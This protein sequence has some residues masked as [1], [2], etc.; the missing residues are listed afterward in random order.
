M[1]RLKSSDDLN[2]YGGEKGVFKDWGR[3]DDDPSL[4]QSSSHRSFHY[5]SESG[6]KG[7]SSSS[8]RY[9]RVEDDRKNS[10]LI[11]K[12]PDYDVDYERRKSYDRYRDSSERGILSSSP[13]GGGGYVG[14]R[15]HRSE[16]FS[17][18]RRDFP[19]GF[20]SE[21]DRSRREGSV[22][23]WRRFSGGKDVEEGAKSGSDSARGSKAAS[24]ERGNVR[25]P[26]GGRDAKSP[27]WSKDSGSEQSKSLEVKKSESLQ[28][29]SGN[30][31]ERE[32]GELEPDPEPEPKPTPIVEKTADDLPSRSLN[33]SKEVQHENHVDDK[34]SE[35]RAKPM[36]KE[37]I[38]P[39]QT[40]NVAEKADVEELE[41]S[42]NVVHKAS[43]SSTSQ[44][45]STQRTGENG[46]AVPYL[47]DNEKKKA[48]PS[49]D[50]NDH[51]EEARD[52]SPTLSPEEIKQ[53]QEN[54]ANLEV[55]EENVNV[56]VHGQVIRNAERHGASGVVNHSLVTKELTKNFKD[57][58]KSVLVSVS[59]ENDFLESN[60][61]V[62]NES[63]GFLASR[64][65]EM[66][67]PS[68]RGFDLFFTDP[69]KKPEN[70]DKKG[71]SKPKDEKLTLEPLE[72][73]LR[74][75]NVLLPI[76]SQ[77]PVQGPDSPSQEMS[78]QS[79]ASSFQTSSD[80]FTVSRSFS[81]SQ[82]FT[83]NPSC[84]LTENSFDFEQSVGSRPLFQGVVWQVQPS[85]EPKNAEPPIQQRSL[86]NGNGIFHQSQTSQGVTNVQ[87][88]QSHGARVAEGSYKL[89][90]GLERQLSSNNKQPS[91]SHSRHRS[92]I[93]SPTQS[94]GSQETGSDYHKDRKRVMRE[95]IGT[96]SKSNNT[97][98]LDMV[99]PLLAMLVSDPLHV[100]ARLLSDMTGPA[101]A[102]LKE[103]VVIKRR[104][105]SAFRKALEK[106]SDIT[107]EMLQKAPSVQVEIL[108]ALKTGIQDFLQ[109]NSDMSSSDLA[110]IFL[111]IRCR[112]LSCR[113][114]LP[115]DE[116]D[117]KICVQKNGFCSA[118]MCLVCS[119]FDMASNTCSWVGCDVCLHWCHTD[120]GLRES[121]IRNG[122]SATGA[123]GQTEMQFHCV[124]CDHPSEMFGFVREVFQN[125]AK[126]WTAEAFSNELEYVRR[127]F[128]ASED[129]RGK[130]L[131]E[132]SLQMLTRMLNK[133]DLQPV[134]SYIMSFLTDDDAFKSDNI[135]IS[136]EKEVVKQN[137]GERSHDAPKTS[138]EAA[139][140]MKSVY[141]DRQP[142]LKTTS[143]EI[144]RVAPI[145]R[146]PVFDELDGIV[147]IKLAEA[148]M[149]QMRADDARREAEGLNRIAQA[150]SKKIDE[151]FASRVTKLHLSEAEEIRRQKLEELQALENAHQEYF[152]MKVRME[153]EIKDLLLK[154]EATK[155]NFN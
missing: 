154:M 133:S 125:F 49:Q 153:R 107:L 140:W 128:S 35:D 80:G 82:H 119:K 127:I 122:R 10:R 85:D 106:R 71:V 108:V 150:K 13:R 42:Q 34:S 143:S 16:S 57:K 94:V 66:E 60:C 112:N 33:A 62:E 105:F 65:I 102:S 96:L 145:P 147:R 139:M 5:K 98:P 43:N 137:Q 39:D 135:Q 92:E 11:R 149:F 118:C 131:H 27:Q 19:K 103:S 141:A 36:P 88:V 72:L 67:G 79:H 144:Q 22:S 86:S 52:V 101:L 41:T 53:K 30:N 59:S 123:L 45:S 114:Y 48:E 12:R 37:E 50:Y 111:N 73:S 51:E 15:I 121:Y 14:D 6:K 77:N 29:E 38:K 109:T 99:E 64:E 116:C 20:R 55:K 148:Q 115:V 21:R 1:K 25:S 70:I 44:D 152:N 40:R 90:L 18:P 124:A 117:C 91:G 32:E 47:S 8:A 56:N 83:H 4:H 134:R 3:K 2:S 95:V 76:G 129:I 26:Q 130:R 151:E 81:G 142:Q 58:G 93:R 61:R 126:G 120:C 78:I 100:V 23:S 68:A 28:A 74:L 146:E 9:E 138:Q 31:S 24:E 7:I 17:G 69:V 46:V 89:P 84:S 110:E 155:R 75:P 63:S 132:I 113:S 136:Q 97:G 104:Q 54:D 87:S